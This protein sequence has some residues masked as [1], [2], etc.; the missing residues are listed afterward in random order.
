MLQELLLIESSLILASFPQTLVLRKKAVRE[1]AFVLSLRRLPDESKTVRGKF[2]CKS[3]QVD[4]QERSER[5]NVATIREILG[6]VHRA[7]TVR[8][9]CRALF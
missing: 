5:R 7:N 4:M 2:F 3:R 9:E 8:S 1:F 6:R